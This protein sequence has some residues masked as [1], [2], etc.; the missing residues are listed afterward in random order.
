MDDDVA[1]PPADE[2]GTGPVATAA[3]PT[4][5]LAWVVPPPPGTPPAGPPGGP[6]SSGPGADPGPP[7]RASRAIVAL[8]LVVGLLTGLG[9]VLLVG[10]TV[11]P[12]RPAATATIP[13][14]PTLPTV[15]AVPGTTAPAAPSTGTGASLDTDA[16]AAR[17]V[18]G[19]VD[20]NTR[21]GFENSRA[22]G[23]GM[24]LAASGEVLTN[25]H[26]V[27]GATSIT[28]T[29]VETGRTY[30]AKVVGTAPDD[31]VA[32]LQLQGASGLKTIPVGNSSSLGRGDTVVAI[33]NAG[34][35]GGDPSVV[36]GTVLGLGRTI[37]A[38]DDDG[39]NAERL[40]DLIE[41]SAPIQPG[42]SGG[43]LANR[44]GDVVGMNTAASVGRPRF[45]AAQNL[46]YAIPLENALSL[47][48]QIE[49]GQA[50]DAIHIGLPAFLG[51]QL[52]SPASRFGGSTGAS[53][54]GAPVGGVESGTPAAS[55][56]L[57]A[58]DTVTSVDGQAVGS[59]A[60]LTRI[61]GSHRPGDKVTIGWTDASGATSS[62]RVTLAT[63][64]AD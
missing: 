4:R 6:P 1:A 19:L 58:G 30:T 3:W 37:T 45:Q 51:V 56:G 44:A 41:T 31:D 49:S 2:A 28:A 17:V 43:A 48:H 62:A 40:S 29:V 5:E 52:A 7:R 54:A 32:V 53:T 46:G 16:V 47:A 20:I 61:L 23:T 15:P 18:P 9:G 55:A 25:N 57:E 34:G 38:S 27:R 11:S 60:D 63:G 26:V 59:T 64:P 10:R 22:A 24:V 8:A 50:S 33:G 35:D 42:D 36:T 39:G 13:A 12:A 21:L 14:A